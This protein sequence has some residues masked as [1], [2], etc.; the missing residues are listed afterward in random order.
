MTIMMLRVLFESER[1]LGDYSLQWLD[2]G[3]LGRGLDHGAWCVHAVMVIIAI[4]ALRVRAKLVTSLLRLNPC[5]TICEV[6]RMLRR[7]L[8]SDGAEVQPLLCEFPAY[9]VADGSQTRV[10]AKSP[11]RRS[12]QPRRGSMRCCCMIPGEENIETAIVTYRKKWHTPTTD[13]SSVFD[14]GAMVVV[15]VEE[16]GWTCHVK[17]NIG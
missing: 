2:A 7:P 17:F 3:R 12:L 9:R 14:V 11:A 10:V 16:K 13:E 5:P 15:V 4:R 6:A 8:I 1:R